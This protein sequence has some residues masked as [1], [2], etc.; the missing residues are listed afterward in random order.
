MSRAKHRQRFSREGLTMY[1][2]MLLAE[3]LMVVF[4][5]AVLL[6]I[7]GHLSVLWVLLALIPSA[8]SIIALATPA[9]GW[10]W[11]R[12]MGGRKPSSRE[13]QLYQ[14]AVEMLQRS[15]RIPLVLPASWFVLDTSELDGAVC[16]ETLMLSSGLLETGYLPAVLAHQLGHLASPDGR[17]AAAANWL[18]LWT[19][20]T[21]PPATLP[22]PRITRLICWTSR[23]PRLPDCGARG[24]YKSVR[25]AHYWQTREYQADRYAAS[26]GQADQ[27]AEFLEN[28]DL[29]HDPMPLRWPSENTC[30]SA[31][32]RIQRL[33][34]TTTQ[35]HP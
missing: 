21:E 35:G 12:R 18:G 2:L 4:R 14:G 8:W 29:I 3:L 32:P 31:A 7:T 17:L 30:P 33:R 6:I 28:H 15:S 20:D 22:L 19:P 1:V 26:L 13:Q 11:K 34:S 25:W 27:L 5:V 10:L 9:G 16:R 24:I 23:R